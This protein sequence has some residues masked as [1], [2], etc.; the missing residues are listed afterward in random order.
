LHKDHIADLEALRDE[1]VEF[2]S[3]GNV[4]DDIQINYQDS[5]DVNNLPSSETDEDGNDE[6]R[7]G[8]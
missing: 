6:S 4:F 3:G 8:K 1:G 7:K 5:D 2:I